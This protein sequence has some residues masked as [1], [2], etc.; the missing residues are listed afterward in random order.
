MGYT[1]VGQEDGLEQTGGWIRSRAWQM[2]E[3]GEGQ[4]LP[5]MVHKL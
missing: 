3:D 5:V 1:Y 2:R 4:K